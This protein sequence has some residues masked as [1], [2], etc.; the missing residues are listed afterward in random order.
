MVSPHCN[1]IVSNNIVVGNKAYSGPGILAALDDPDIIIENNNVWENHG[2]N[3]HY[4]DPALSE[5][6][7]F[8]NGPYGDYYLSNS[9]AGE[10]EDSPCIDFGNN[11]AEY[12]E[13][14]FMT[15]RTDSGVDTGTVDLGY[16]YE[17]E[18]Y[19]VADIK[20]NK[21]IYNENDKFS[22]ELDILNVGPELQAHVYVILELAGCY[23]FWPSWEMEP[24]FQER[25]LPGNSGESERILEFVW[26]VI[27]PG[28]QSSATLW[29]AVME[30]GTLNILSNIDSVD[31]QYR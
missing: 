9:A 20:T 10:D 5:D 15:T 13:L 28:M 27:T 19:I 1:A 31:F 22:S 12:W 4:T 11:T 21:E 6:P 7:L 14:D 25:I 16:H 23:W 3:P 24:D 30:P 29:T 17:P 26:P 2:L 8:V 18:S